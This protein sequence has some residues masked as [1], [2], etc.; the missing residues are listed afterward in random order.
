[1]REFLAKTS[2][3]DH[4][5]PK[6]MTP[7]MKRCVLRIF[8][9]HYDSL[10]LRFYPGH[11]LEKDYTPTM[12]PYWK[13]MSTKPYSKDVSVKTFG[14]FQDRKLNGKNTI[15]TMA[16][17]LFLTKQKRTPGQ[18][19]LPPQTVQERYA[20]IG[21]DVDLK[22]FD[23]IFEDMGFLKGVA[24]AAKIDGSL[25]HIPDEWQKSKNYP[26]T[27]Y[28]EEMSFYSGFTLED[29][30]KADKEEPSLTTMRITKDKDKTKE[31]YKVALIPLEFDSTVPGNEYVFMYYVSEA[32]IQSISIKLEEKIRT[33]RG[34]II[35]ISTIASAFTIS[36]VICLCYYV[37]NTIATPL[38]KLILVADFLNNNATEKDVIGTLEITEAEEGECQVK[39]LVKAFKNLLTV[40]DSKDKNKNLVSKQMQTEYPRNQYSS[41]FL[42]QSRGTQVIDWGPVLQKIQDRPPTVYSLSLIH[43]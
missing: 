17:N 31:A 32:T 8:I 33:Q 16:V 28:D 15:F 36:V 20:L 3:L 25:L 42:E 4:L 39:D 40:L 14:P 24:L 22:E 23:S 38:K 9:I 2:P 11:D 43:I 27:I 29:W 10:T 18:E 13:E 6:L 30:K 35:F 26:R 41:T 5:L 12:E 21:V 19:D 34:L 37:A 1:M 7:K